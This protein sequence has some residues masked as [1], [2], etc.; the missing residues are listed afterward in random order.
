MKKLF[1]MTLRASSFFGPD[2]RNEESE[3]AVRDLFNIDSSADL[4]ATLVTLNLRLED[5]LWSLFTQAP[6]PASPLKLA[7]HKRRMDKIAEALN[8]TLSSD[9]LPKLGVDVE[10]IRA[11][12]E[13][14]AS[15]AKITVPFNAV[16]V[17]PRDEMKAIPLPA[18]N[19]LRDI[20]FISTLDK[21]FDE[22]AAA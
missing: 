22:A 20:D 10:L 12:I 15:F 8:G 4:D 17:Q 9:D 7:A 21:L 5:F 19:V 13:E 1:E 6:Q 11:L 18:L 14:E 3:K 16:P 2:D